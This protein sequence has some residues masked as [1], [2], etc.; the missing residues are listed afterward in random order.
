MPEVKSAELV[1][2]LILIG[3]RRLAELNAA[4]DRMRAGGPEVT[5]AEI[6]AA[7]L[8]ADA[9]ILRAREQVNKPTG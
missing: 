7:G 5:A 6:D 8:G 2:E 9:A 4:Y 3:L 1:A